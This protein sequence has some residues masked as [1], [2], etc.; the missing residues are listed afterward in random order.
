M[1]NLKEGFRFS[2][3]DAEA[4][5]FLL[6]FIAG[7][8]MNDSG[9]ITTHVVTVGGL[10]LFPDSVFPDCVNKNHG[11]FTLMEYPAVMTTTVVSIASSSQSSR[12]KASRDVGN[13]G[14]WKQQDKSK[15][16]R[17]NGGPVIGYKKA[18][19]T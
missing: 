18:C 7:K 9:F 1:E 14:S 12:R 4:V 2:P 3:S 6:R 8:F 15:P 16:V 17:K 19:V 11:T 5:T 10:D 13:K